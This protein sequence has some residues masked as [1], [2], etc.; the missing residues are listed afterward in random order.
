M[1]RMNTRFNGRSVSIAQMRIEQLT[2]ENFESRHKQGHVYLRRLVLVGNDNDPPFFIALVLHQLI[3][4]ADRAHVSWIRMQ[5][6][7]RPVFSLSAII[8]EWS[9]D[10]EFERG[11]PQRLDRFGRWIRCSVTGPGGP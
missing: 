6:I 11:G 10:L 9:H 1:N 8:P 4:I 5:K 2:T 3:C 7:L